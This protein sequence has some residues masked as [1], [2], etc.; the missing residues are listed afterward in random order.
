VREAIEIPEIDPPFST[1]D[2]LA[3]DHLKGALKLFI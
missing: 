1:C 3:V 2:C